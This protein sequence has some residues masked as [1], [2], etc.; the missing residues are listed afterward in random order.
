M[1]AGDVI[2]LAVLGVAVGA[3]A[4]NLWKNRNKGCCGNC[5]GC[6]QCCRQETDGD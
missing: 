4:A 2:V 6:T 3:I 5:A 1:T